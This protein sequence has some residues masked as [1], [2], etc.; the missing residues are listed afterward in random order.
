[1]TSEPPI[2]PSRKKDA[3]LTGLMGR[4]AVLEEKQLSLKREVDEMKTSTASFME[5]VS[6]TLWVVESLEAIAA[7]IGGP[8]RKGIEMV[9]AAA[10]IYLVTHIHFAP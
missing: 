6:K 1:M 3:S 10:I 9:I 2:G 8:L 4:I 7:T 5:R